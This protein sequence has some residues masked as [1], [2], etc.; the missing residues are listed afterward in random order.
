LPSDSQSDNDETD[1]TG[2]FAERGLSA[3]APEATSATRFPDASTRI[4]ERS[5]A[6]VV[7]QASRAASVMAADASASVGV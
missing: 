1:T 2:G 3:G 6:D 4:G 7:V 5:G